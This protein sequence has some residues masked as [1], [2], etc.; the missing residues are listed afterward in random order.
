MTQR[1]LVEFEGLGWCPSAIRD[2]GTEWLQLLSER[3]GLYEPVLGKLEV[4]LA[5]SAVHEVVDLCTARVAAG[6]RSYGHWMRAVTAMSG[7]G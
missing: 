3:V 5:A 1:H 7:C 4:L 2:L 6:H